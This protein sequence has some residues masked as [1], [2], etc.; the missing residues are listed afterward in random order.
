MSYV[1]NT[2]LNDLNPFIISLLF[3]FHASLN[4]HSVVTK[5]DTGYFLDMVPHLATN[6]TATLVKSVRRRIA[7][8]PSCIYVYVLRTQDHS[9]R[10]TI[11]CHP[12]RSCRLVLANQYSVVITTQSDSR[13]LAILLAA[14]TQLSSFTYIGFWHEDPRLL[15]PKDKVREPEDNQ[16]PN[17]LFVSRKALFLLC[18]TTLELI[19]PSTRFN[20]PF[21]F[22]D[23][24]HLSPS[25]EVV[26]LIISRPSAS[27]GP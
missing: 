7:A 25:A 19:L 15:W 11:L 5:D 22:C 21:P 24:S 17:S 3:T 1:I 27:H 13:G 14:L 10:L 26:V 9:D 8:V 6:D 2:P 20:S 23:C 12:L 16:H 4:P 18:V